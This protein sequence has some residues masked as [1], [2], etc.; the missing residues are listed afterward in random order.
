M[1]DMSLYGMNI[2]YTLT[3]QLL[4]DR[5]ALNIVC[6]CGNQGVESQKALLP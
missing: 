3:L 5:F 1:I 4:R 6:T 2:H